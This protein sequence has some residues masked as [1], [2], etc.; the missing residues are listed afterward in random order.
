MTNTAESFIFP[1]IDR[2]LAKE[3]PS[4]DSFMQAVAESTWINYKRKLGQIFTPLKEALNKLSE[5]VTWAKK[6]DLK[7]A[8]NIMDALLSFAHGANPR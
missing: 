4:A 8:I 2:I 5:H 6:P 7:K 3:I 1:E